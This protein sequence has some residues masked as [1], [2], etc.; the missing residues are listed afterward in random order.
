MV[1]IQ[2]FPVFGVVNPVFA[3][4]PLC[5]VIFVTALKDGYEDLKRHRE[6]NK[7]NNTEALILDNWTN[8]NFPKFHISFM[9]RVKSTILKFF[10]WVTQSIPKQLL[11]FFPNTELEEENEGRKEKN[12]DPNI[13][14]EPIYEGELLNI[15]DTNTP[16][17]YSKTNLESTLNRKSQVDLSVGPDKNIGWKT[18]AWQNIRVGDIILLS[19]DENVPA[20]IVILSTSEE[21]NECYVETKNLDGETTLKRRTGKK[22]TQC[23]RD[24]KSAKNMRFVIKAENPIVNLY[25]FRSRIELP[26]T[27]SE[28]GG[29][30]GVDDEEDS[31]P[32]DRQSVQSMKEDE[33]VF[34]NGKISI[35]L[36]IT[37]LLLR[38]SVIRNTEWVIGAVIYTLN[39]LSILRYTIFLIINTTNSSIF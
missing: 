17:S 7:V 9:G 33:E 28:Y 39:T 12:S 8:T 24:V 4:M 6:D 5:C 11:V 25:E 22:E 21:E 20:D 18:V 14:L 13:K 32:Q 23:I 34:P 36:D 10:R 27:E 2:A 1:T 30:G 29:V 26:D 38:G 31:I 35:P 19:A 16:S 3:A 15:E 37:N